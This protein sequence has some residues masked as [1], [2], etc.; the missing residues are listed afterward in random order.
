[1]ARLAGV[2]L[3]VLVLAGCATLADLAALREDL[4][5]AG[6][7]A[8][9][10]DHNTTNGYSELSIDVS[11]LDEPTFAQVEDIGR[12]V[13][14][15]FDGEID[16]MHITINGWF[17]FTESYDKLLVRYGERPEDLPGDDGSDD[18][19]LTLILVVA[20]VAV[21]FTALMVLLWHR[22]RRAAQRGQNRDSPSLS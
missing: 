17:G 16:R 18:S 11:I 4:E 13:W 3:L 20:G 5:S 1:M 7:D 2:F 10:I 15:T 9:S 14:T 8:P 19:A 12:V 21:V 6:Y 22:S